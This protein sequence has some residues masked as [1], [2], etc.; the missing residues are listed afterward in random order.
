MPW[1]YQPC[2]EKKL[3]PVPKALPRETIM[4]KGMKLA[5]VSYGNAGARM[6][7]TKSVPTEFV[8]YLAGQMETIHDAYLQEIK[9]KTNDKRS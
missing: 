7:F 5:E 2:C 9:A 3:V 4:S 8:A 1:R 6:N